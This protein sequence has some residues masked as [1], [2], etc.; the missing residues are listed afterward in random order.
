MCVCVI[1]VVWWCV[2]ADEQVM[3]VIS[4]LLVWWFDS[5]ELFSV[6]ILSFNENWGVAQVCM[7]KC[8]TDVISVSVPR[9]TSSHTLSLSSWNSSSLK[10]SMRVFSDVNTAL[11]NST[12]TLCLWQCRYKIKSCELQEHTTGSV[13][14]LFHFIVLF[15]PSRV[16]K[17]VFRFSCKMISRRL[18]FV[19]VQ[20]C[21]N[22]FRSINGRV[23]EH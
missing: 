23:A 22:G 10:L 19:K 12:H 16:L 21:R 14:L 7:Y 6:H 3:C 2:C 5:V 8:V 1:C 9:L 13:Y 11:Y 15:D 4:F 17:C 18:T 20:E